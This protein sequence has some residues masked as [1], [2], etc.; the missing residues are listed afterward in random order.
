MSVIPEPSRASE[1]VPDASA[2]GGD[3]SRASEPVPDASADGQDPSRASEPVPDASAGGEDPSRAGEPV[4][5]ASVGGEDLL[6]MRIGAALIDLAMLLVLFVVLAVVVGEAIVNRVGVAFSFTLDGAEFAVYVSLALLYYLVLEAAIGQTVGKLLVGLRVVRAG[7][8]RP[9][10]WKVAARTVV[11]VVDWLPAFYLVGFIAM[12]AT[13]ARRQRLGDLAAGTRIARAVPMRHRGLAATG[14]ASSLVLV[15]AGSVV[16]VAASDRDEGAQTYRGNGV[17]FDYPAGWE[18]GT[19]ETVAETGNADELWEVAFGLGRASLVSVTAYRLTPPV[20]AENLDAAKAEFEGAARRLF[21]QVGGT[22]R[23]GPEEITVAGRPGLRF[24]ATGTHDGTSFEST[25]VLIFDGT[26]QYT[27]NCS[28][29]A[30]WAEEIE[31]GCEQIVRTFTVDMVETESTVPP[32]AETPSP[33][34]A[35]ETARPGAGAVAFFDLEVGDC[36][37][38]LI[39]TLG[40][41]FTVETVPCSQPHSEEIYAVVPLPEGDFPGDEAVGV[42]ADKACN[43]EFESFVGLPYQESVLYYNS[44]YPNDE[45]TWNSVFREVVCSV[46]DPD[47]EVSGSLRGV[48]R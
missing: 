46:Y 5:D 44:L 38:D 40:E 29:T 6:G 32:A 28:H 33:A 19:T 42:Q 4:P 39:A 1:A 18:E 35:E 45:Q 17:S 26:T 13:G 43:A 3:P 16:Y 31:R 37:A 22:V 30:E 23:A 21:D 47:G 20:T 8:G 7:G 48:E 10:V 27:L 25:L 9:N 34:L 15:L 24:Q 11:R 36:L 12:L 41:F 2:D 14:L